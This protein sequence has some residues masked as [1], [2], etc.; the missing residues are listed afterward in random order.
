[1]NQEH[2]YLSALRLAV[3]HLCGKVFTI[4]CEDVIFSTPF[5]YNVV[6]G[7][8]HNFFTREGWVCV[9]QRV[10]Y[11]PCATIHHCIHRLFLHSTVYIT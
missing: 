2:L 6:V 1:M 11:F 10:V 8:L 5:F 7:S 3:T 9:I 4:A